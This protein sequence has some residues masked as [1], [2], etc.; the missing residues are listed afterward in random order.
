MMAGVVQA[1]PLPDAVPV[2]LDAIRADLAMRRLSRS[3]VVALLNEVARLRDIAANAEADRELA[4]AAMAQGRQMATL[5]K[6]RRRASF[7]AR[8]RAH[9]A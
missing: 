2:D 1:P 7:G 3:A 4:A 5:R 9:A 6:T 8:G